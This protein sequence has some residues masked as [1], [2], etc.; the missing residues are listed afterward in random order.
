MLFWSDDDLMQT[1]A[2]SPLFDH[3][4]FPTYSLSACERTKLPNLLKEFCDLFSPSHGPLGQTSVITHSMST[5]AAPIH[6][7]IASMPSA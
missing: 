3:S 4:Q 5:T 2:Q 1:E 6:Q 7:P